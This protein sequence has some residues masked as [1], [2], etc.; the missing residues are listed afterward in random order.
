MR[1]IG[2]GKLPDER[3]V[4][5]ILQKRQR[6]TQKAARA[7]IGRAQNAVRLVRR[8]LPQK[9]QRLILRHRAELQL[10][11]AA[12]DG[13]QQP[14]RVGRQDQEHA[15]I[16]RLLQ[17]LQQ[18]VL[19]GFVHILPARDDVDLALSLVR[20][21]EHIASGCADGV[22]GHGLVVGIVDGDDIRV[23]TL[24]RL[25]AAGADA[26]GDLSAAPLALHCRR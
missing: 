7:Q 15:V 24:K 3:L 4:L 23:D 18:R 10:R 16:R 13:R 8:I 11:A 1:G 22:D 9:R 20:A 12:A 5:R 19:R 26:A 21:D 25:A 2:R 14:L 17:N 6:L